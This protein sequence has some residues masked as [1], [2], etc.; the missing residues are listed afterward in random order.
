MGK[1][2][3]IGKLTFRVFGNDHLPPHFHVKGG[4][5]EALVTIND[6]EV[7]S[8]YLPSDIRK[9]V[10]AWA[11]ENRDRLAAEWNTWNPHIPYA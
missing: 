1:L 10:F 11:V 4:G 5:V 2:G 3:T 7:I 9:E 6:P 8:G